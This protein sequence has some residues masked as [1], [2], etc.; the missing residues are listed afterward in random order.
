M[1]MRRCRLL[2]RRRSGV[3]VHGTDENKPP[4]ACGTRRPSNLQ[5]RIDIGR[6]IGVVKRLLTQLFLMLLMHAGRAVNHRIGP[7]EHA[8]SEFCEIVAGAD[9][10]VAALE[11]KYARPTADGNQTAPPTQDFRTK[12]RAEKARRARHG[13]GGVC[14]VIM[15]FMPRYLL[16]SQLPTLR[17]QSQPPE[18]RFAPAAFH[19]AEP[20]RRC[21]PWAK[22][23]APPRA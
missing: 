9:H 18:A 13:N 1:S 7:L 17:P 10:G 8:G 23:P 12:M 4:H 14:F 5:R 2:G 11:F 16:R 19:K 20:N 21:R 22:T 3:H 6:E 15:S